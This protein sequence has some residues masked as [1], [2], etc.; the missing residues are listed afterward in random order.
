MALNMKAH[1]EREITQQSARGVSRSL[2]KL[3]FQHLAGQAK[4]E[5]VN[6]HGRL[7]RYGS[8]G[9]L[10]AECVTVGSGAST[11]RPGMPCA[12][13]N[14]GSDWIS[15]RGQRLSE[16]FAQRSLG[17]LSSELYG[18]VAPRARNK[19]SLNLIA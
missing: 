9:Y 1:T 4:I 5:C 3:G 10:C 6:S 18:N 12:P 19:R 7:P 17:K 11:T 15:V 2:A 13:A 14:S 16:R 8:M